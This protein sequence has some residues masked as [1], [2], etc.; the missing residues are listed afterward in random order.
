[1]HTGIPWLIQTAGYTLLFYAIFYTM[2]T[3]F[4]TSCFTGMQSIS[5]P[6]HSEGPQLM[7]IL[8][9]TEEIYI[10]Q[11][12]GKFTTSRLLTSFPAEGP[13]TSRDALVAQVTTWIMNETDHGLGNAL[14]GIEDLCGDDFGFSTE[15]PCFFLRLNRIRSRVLP[16]T[17]GD[18]D[19][20][21]LVK[22]Y[23]NTFEDASQSSGATFVGVKC[24]HLNGIAEDETVQFTV[25]SFLS[26]EESV[27]GFAFMPFQ[28]NEE[29]EW[30]R[31]PIVV[32]KPDNVPGGDLRLQYDK[33]KCTLDLNLG[34]ENP[35]QRVV[36]SATFTIGA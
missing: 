15:T 8:D 3:G 23:R 20:I 25:K 4:W 21:D 22:K 26:N 28:N 13:D 11:Y 5:V 6:V 36:Q 30:Y 2:L 16:E 19:A 10:Q 33:I 17:K 7:D 32:V 31:D 29:S 34:A 18:N 14:G 9:S 12:P 35:S 24:I 1:M 27:N